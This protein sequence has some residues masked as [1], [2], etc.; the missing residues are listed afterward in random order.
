VLKKK[1]L[2]QDKTGFIKRNGKNINMT[3]RERKFQNVEFNNLYSS[4]N[5]VSLLK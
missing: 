4:P 2:L 3:E 1:S 5:V